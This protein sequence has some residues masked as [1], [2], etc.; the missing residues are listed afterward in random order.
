MHP[1]IYHD[2]KNDQELLVFIRNQPIWY[3]YLSR[4]PLQWEAFKQEAKK[5]HG[6]TLRQRTEKLSNQVKMLHL[7]YELTKST[8]N[9]E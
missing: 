6:K 7:L 4:D 9:Q 1:V 8:N 5:W 3:R 2:L